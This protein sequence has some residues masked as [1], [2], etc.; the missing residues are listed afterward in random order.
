MGF[1]S[2]GSGPPRL[3]PRERGPPRLDVALGRDTG[4][5]TTGSDWQRRQRRGCVTRPERI[6]MFGK[7]RRKIPGHW[8]YPRPRSWWHELPA[9]FHDYHY[10]LVIRRRSTPR[11]V[12]HKFVG[13][14][15]AS[16]PLAWWNGAER[17]GWFEPICFVVVVVNC[18]CHHW[19]G[20]DLRQRHRRVESDKMVVVVVVVGGSGM[21]RWAAKKSLFED[22]ISSVVY[23]HWCRP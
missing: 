1:P 12:S 15:F 23:Y 14:I 21:E 2:T 9:V 13:A 10:Q 4:S 3:P 20:K 22:G 11:R 8:Y 17:R 5:D 18:R 6:M 16:G 19:H 7:R